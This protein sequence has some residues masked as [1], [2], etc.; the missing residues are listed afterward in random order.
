[1]R[2]F[3]RDDNIEVEK[4]KTNLGRFHTCGIQLHEVDFDAAS[5]YLHNTLRAY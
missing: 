5:T 1:V 4:T 3:C 2:M